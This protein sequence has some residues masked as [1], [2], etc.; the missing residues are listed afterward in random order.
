MSSPRKLTRPLPSSRFVKPSY[1]NFVQPSSKFADII[2]PGAQN[3]GEFSPPSFLNSLATKADLFVLFSSSVAVELIVTH[4]RRQLS[5][6]SLRFRSQLSTASPGTNTPTS[7]SPPNLVLLEQTSGLSVL[8][9][10]LRDRE[11]SRDDFIQFS[12]RLATLWVTSFSLKFRATQKTTL[13]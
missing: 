1:D 12:D 3:N 9:T 2:V 13:R 8:V 6:R 7:S 10:F 5:D 4:I 11:T